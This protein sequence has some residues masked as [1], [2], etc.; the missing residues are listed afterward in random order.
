M[1]IETRRLI[2][3]PWEPGDFAD[4]AEILRDPRVMYAYEHAFSDAD[5]WAWLERQLA[6]YEKNGFGLCAVV[7]K[8]GGAVVGQAGL[9]WQDCQG[10]QVLEIG[11][12]LKYG[13]WH[14]GYAAEAA[15]GCRRY[16]FEALGAPAVYSIIK[17]DNIPSQKVAERVGMHR[18]KEFWAT[19]YAAP[20]LHYLY[21][22]ERE[23]G[24]APAK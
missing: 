12:H 11:Y 2:L 20:M 5:V 7:K 6:R 1:R 19:Y 24:R 13:D 8:Q 3:R 22:V 14:Q 18:L 16:A 17:S 10:E 9:F 21:G 15:Q 23:E 4:L